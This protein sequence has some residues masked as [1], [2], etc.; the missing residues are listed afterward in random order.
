MGRRRKKIQTTLGQPPASVATKPAEKPP[1]SGFGDG[2]AG[3]LAMIECHHPVAFAEG[4][5]VPGNSDLWSGMRFETE[6][7]RHECDGW[8]LEF[9]DGTFVQAIRND[10]LSAFVD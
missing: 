4:I 3:H 5:F 2:A 8:M 6:D 1:V 7:G 9:K 10:R